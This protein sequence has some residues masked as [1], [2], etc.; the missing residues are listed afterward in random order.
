MS[1]RTSSCGAPRERDD[2]RLC[3]RASAEVVPITT[4]LLPRTPLATYVVADGRQAILALCGE[5]DIATAGSVWSAVQELRCAGATSI[6]IDLR[7]LEFMDSQGPHILLALQRECDLD[8]ITM[9][10][11]AGRRRVQR[12][13]ELTGT[14]SGFDWGV[15]HECATL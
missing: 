13:F 15:M 5:L 11:V 9:A 7:S 6:L 1:G 3:H 14:S 12:V 8:G 10:L 2:A 4:H